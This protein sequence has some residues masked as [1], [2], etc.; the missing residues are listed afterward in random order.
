MLLS[1]CSAPKGESYDS[2]KLYKSMEKALYEGQTEITATY[3]ASSFSEET[4]SADA[5][6]F[7][8]EN[9]LATCLLSDIEVSFEK[10]GSDTDA[11][12]SLI[13]NEA[14]DFDGIIVKVSDDTKARKVL[15]KM[16]EDGGQKTALLLS[17][18]T[19]TET[20][21]F[22]LLDEAEV[23]CATAPCEAT[24]LSYALFDPNESENTQLLVVWLEYAIDENDFST[25]EA[26]LTA[27]I[28]NYSSKLKSEASSDAEIY[29]SIFDLVCETANYDM[30]IEELTKLDSTRLTSSMHVDRSAYGALVSKNTVCTGYAR[31][32][33]ALCDE[34]NLP[35]YVILGEINGGNHCWNAVCIDGETFYVDCTLADTNG[36]PLDPFLFTPESARD[37]G[38]VES[39]FCNIPW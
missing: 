30:K 17:D 34:L 12:F 21:I 37:A 18:Y 36:A 33:K 23:N 6:Q 1:G 15:K 11:T 9:Y 35:C 29:H 24:Q 38:Y 16:T 3:D 22:G 8:S 31:G 26:E 5:K 4:A 28:K 7:L 27:A 2:D 25:K 14:T 20:E 10:S 32:F 13:Y 39:S 19:L